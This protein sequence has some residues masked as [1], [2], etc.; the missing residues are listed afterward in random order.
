MEEHV[1]TIEVDRHTSRSRKPE[2]ARHEK[3]LVSPRVWTSDGVRRGIIYC[4]I[5]SRE[6]SRGEKKYVSTVSS[7]Q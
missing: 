5:Q 2:V 1:L 7:D 4:V 3:W 6:A